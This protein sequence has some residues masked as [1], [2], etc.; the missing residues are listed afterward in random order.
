MKGPFIL[1][2]M[3]IR[4]I[5][6]AMN[7]SAAE[8]WN[9]TETD[10]RFLIENPENVCLLA[11]TGG[12]VIG[13]TTAINYSNEVAWIGMVLVNREYRDLGVAKS[14]LTNVLNQV[15]NCTSIKL[16]ATPAGQQVYQKLGFKE[17]YLIA[18]M[19][20]QLVQELASEEHDALLEPVQPEDLREIIAL[21][22]LVFGAN[23]QQL[24]TFLI[25]Q[26]SG[27]SWVLKRNKKIAGFV[28]G[29]D[30]NRYHHIGPLVAKTT[31][32]AKM[33]VSKALSNLSKQPVVVDVLCDKNEL[34]D[35]L[36][37]LGFSQQRDFI[38]MYKDE[39]SFPGTGDNQY[40][41]CGPEF[42]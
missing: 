23:R 27:K 28:L 32:D 19:T 35:W 6:A 15:K 20:N 36:K 22:S 33:L 26:F 2:S 12:Q 24:I 1:R 4:E 9:Q 5:N 18:R 30:G 34:I 25:Q 37:I 8:G 7:L 38:R 41:I 13:T 31:N 17:E 3:T 10:W 21:D 16:D 42:G 14:L 40:L 29:R 39:N 11:E